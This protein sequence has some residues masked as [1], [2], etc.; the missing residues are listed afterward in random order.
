[1]TDPNSIIEDINKFVKEVYAKT[2]LPDTTM[3]LAQ[4]RMVRSLG[5][6]M[7]DNIKDDAMV[8]VVTTDNEVTITEIE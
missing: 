7:D 3:F 2:E 1:M 5:I 6:K 8:Q 4:A